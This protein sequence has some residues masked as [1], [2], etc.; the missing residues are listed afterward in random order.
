[1]QLGTYRIEENNNLVVKPC[2]NRFL[3][4]K[5]Y[6]ISVRLKHNVAGFNIFS[7]DP[8]ATSNN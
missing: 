8:G 5:V 6:C 3:K 4:Y 1:M 2:D 7:M